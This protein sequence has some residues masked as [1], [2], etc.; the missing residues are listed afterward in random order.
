MGARSRRKSA[1][2]RSKGVAA[3]AGAN[4]PAEGSTVRGLGV[5]PTPNGWLGAPAR[6]AAVAGGFADP[7]EADQWCSVPSFCAQCDTGDRIPGSPPPNPPE[8]PLASGGRG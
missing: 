3:V 6:R 2:W 1:A 4:P 7:G 8:R 5:V